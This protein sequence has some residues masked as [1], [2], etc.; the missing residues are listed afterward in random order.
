VTLFAGQNG[1]EKWLG[2]P[3]SDTQL[4]RVKLEVINE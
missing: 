4:F 3:D 1:L 2:I